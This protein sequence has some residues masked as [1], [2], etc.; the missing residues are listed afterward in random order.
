M[1]G[2]PAGPDLGRARVAD[3][4]LDV[5][6]MEDPPLEHREDGDPE[7]DRERDPAAAPGASSKA[8]GMV[9]NSATPIIAPPA[10]P[11]AM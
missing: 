1:G 5:D 9:S 3:R 4:V 10:N 7:D 2:D 11:I 6:V 8:S